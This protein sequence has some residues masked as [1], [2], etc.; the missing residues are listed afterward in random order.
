MTRQQWAILARHKQ[1]IAAICPD[2]KDEAGIYVF[3]RT[4]EQG[5]GYAY[6]GQAKH[7][8]TRAAQHLQGFQH[9]DL[10]LKKRGLYDAEKNPTG[11]QLSVYIYCDPQKLDELEKYAI[12]LY[13]KNSQMLNATSGGQGVG[14]QALGE[15]KSPRGYRDG[16]AYGYDKA[17]KEVSILFQ[18]YLR[19]DIAGTPTKIKTKKLDNFC[20]T[21]YHYQQKGE[22]NDAETSE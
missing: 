3:T 16:V 5:I 12:S 17:W 20:D 11:W 10:S 14:K 4:D 7:L 21:L 1:K 13:A 2:A 6:V 22:K 9:I 19:V 15:A 18:K 8:L